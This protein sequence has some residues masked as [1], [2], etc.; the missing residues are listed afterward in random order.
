VNVA[1]DANLDA[2]HLQL[3]EHLW[4]VGVRMRCSDIAVAFP[5]RKRKLVVETGEPKLEERCCTM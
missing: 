4:G 5:N 1:D 3:A 2:A